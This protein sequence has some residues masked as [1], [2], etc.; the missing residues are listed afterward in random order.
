MNPEDNLM[1][2]NKTETQSGRIPILAIFLTAVLTL[3]IAGSAA[4]YA[5]LISPAGKEPHETEQD[6]D[7]QYTCS[8]HPQ[9]VQDEPGNC[10][11]CGME[12]VPKDKVEEEDASKKGEREVAYWRAPMNPEEIYDKPGKSAMG[13]ELE[14]VYEDELVGGVNISIDPVMEQNMGIRTATVERGSLE[15]TIRTYGHVTYN[16]TKMTRVNLKFSGWI[17]KLYVDFTGARVKKGEP[18]FAFY[19]PELITAQQDLLEAHRNY[20]RRPDDTNKRV[21]ESVKSR[22]RY[23]EIAESE[24]EE[25]LERGQVKHALTIRCPYTGVV[26]EKNA[27]EGDFVK[28]GATIYQI[29]DLSSVWVEAHIY[30][31]ELARVEKGQQ[32]EMTLPYLPG[33]KY[34]GQVAYVYPYLQRKTRDVVVLL[35]FDN[36]DLFLK[37][38]MYGDVRIGTGEGEKGI[39]V[40]RSAVLRS[41]ERDIVFVRRDAGKFTPRE[42]KLGMPLDNDRM[43]I[44]E[45]LA[46]GEQVVTSGQF[47]LDS[48]S[49]LR[50]ASQKMTEREDLAEKDGTSEEN[51][52]EEDFFDDMEDDPDDD[53]FFEDIE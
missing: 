10:P 35:E 17:E 26:T 7:I 31:Y 49:K 46:P 24:I 48:E 44:L 50:E 8:M 16:E 53:A 43:Q 38:D 51:G 12:L 5:G 6:E 19:S 25:I 3:A 33:E 37:P 4:W 18:M 27:Q 36:P 1:T 52:P 47:M 40:P 2:T 39:H 41:G 15:H 23:Y 34:T 30:E 13:M 14:P 20:S 9:V 42:V 28:S 21:L 32:A 22:L 29:A 11:I 45:G